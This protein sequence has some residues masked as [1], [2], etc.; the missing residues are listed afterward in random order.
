MRTRVQGNKKE[1]A[2]FSYRAKFDKKKF[3]KKMLFFTDIC[4][5]HGI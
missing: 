2:K 3:D 4:M 5:A 1:H